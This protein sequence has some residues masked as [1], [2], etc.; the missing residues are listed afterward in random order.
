MV[1]ISE[2]GFQYFESLGPI[3]FLDLGMDPNV[4]ALIGGISIGLE[5]IAGLIVSS[6]EQKEMTVREGTP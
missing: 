6:Y 1:F 3:V 4:Y 5:C 2:V